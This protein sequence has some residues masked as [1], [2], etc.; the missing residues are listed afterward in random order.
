MAELVQQ[1]KSSSPLDAA[2]VCPPAIAVVENVADQDQDAESLTSTRSSHKQGRKG[3]VCQRDKEAVATRRWG[4][5]RSSP[6]GRRIADLADPEHE[7]PVRE[8]G[9]VGGI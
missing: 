2:Q 4:R 6:G 9:A 1:D 7:A 3:E 5:G 8:S